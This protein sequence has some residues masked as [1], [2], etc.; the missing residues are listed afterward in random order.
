MTCTPSAVQPLSTAMRTGS[1]EEHEAAEGSSFMT[2]LLA[3]E[4]NEAGYA[5]YLGQ[6]WH[7]YA[8]L[9]AT[10]QARA[11]DGMV[12]AVYDP[13]LERLG[14]LEADL[15]YWS[16]R[17]GL[18]AA[19]PAPTAA[20]S[21]YAERVVQAGTWGGLLVA[22]HYTRYLGDLAGGQ[23]IGRMLQRHFDTDGAGVAFYDFERIPHA[24]PY[25]DGYR[26]RLDALDLTSSERDL[27]VA[28][29]R[30][31]FR[32]NRALFAELAERLPTYRR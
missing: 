20:A 25:R 18:P 10:I 6:L 13:A 24:K 31:A 17:A 15:A 27:L 12:A 5:A 11:T 23:V 8:A 16:R 29:V 28:E 9:E 1:R 4:V 22:H 14:K 19:P 2:A 32:L 7:A 26:A 21:A 30:N 3:G